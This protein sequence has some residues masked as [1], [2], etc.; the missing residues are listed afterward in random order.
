MDTHFL[1][2]FTWVPKNW[3]MYVVFSLYLSSKTWT[4]ISFFNLPE[5]KSMDIHLLLPF[6]WVQ[7]Y[8]CPSSS[9]LYLSSEIFMSIFV[10][11]L[12]EFRNIIV[13][14]LIH[15]SRGQ[16]Q[17]CPTRSSLYPSPETLLSISFPLPESRNM[18][19]HLLPFTW[20]QKHGCPSPSSCL[21]EQKCSASLPRDLVKSENKINPN[22]DYC[23]RKRDK[24][25]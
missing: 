25:C 20:V 5:P 19:V 2:P 3:C 13:F 4:S 1:L 7:K 21:L 18:D 22:A 17:G 16:K 9:S 15:L 23:L 14:L 12:S 24:L 10:F 8:L 11:P 6:T